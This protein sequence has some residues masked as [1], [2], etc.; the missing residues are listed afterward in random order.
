M[1]ETTAPSGPAPT[2]PAQGSQSPSSTPDQTLLGGNAQPNGDTKPNGD[3][4]PGEGGKP[5]E[6]AAKAPDKYEFK[7]ADGV[8]V[9]TVALEAY[10]P[11]MRDLNLTQEQAQKL[12][13]VYAEQTAKQAEAFAKQLEDPA[14]ALQ[15]ASLA[16]SAQRDKWAAAVKSDKDLGGTNLD[17]NMQVMQRAIARFG[18][19]ELKQLLNATGLGNHPELARF[20]L[21]V[22]QAISEDNPSAG[23]AGGGARKT[24]EDVFYPPQ[25]A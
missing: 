19:P 12:A 23:Q 6:S 10:T 22:G 21:K 5:P 9:D 13:N 1:T 17:A 20:C 8:V 3:A 16:L 7:F 24:N 25:S 14:F 11:A 15:Q 2:Q 18:S 4:K